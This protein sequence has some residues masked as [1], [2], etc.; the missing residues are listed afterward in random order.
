VDVI[1]PRNA[2]LSFSLL[3]AM[4][5]IIASGAGLIMPGVLYAKATPNWYAQSFGQDIVDFFI[6]VPML[7]ITS[8]L[9]YMKSRK[10]LLLW[11]GVMIY[12]I[13]TF[14]IYCFAVHFN[15]LFVLYCLIL[16]L[17]FYLFVWFILSQYRLKIT[18]WF[19][20]TLPY[21]TISIYILVIGSIFYLLWLMQIIPANINNTVPKELQSAGLFTNPV[22]VLDL[23]VCLPGIIITGILLYRNHPAG[24]L[25]APVVLMFFILMDIT[26]GGLMLVMKWKGLEANMLLTVNMFV[27]AFISAVLLIIYFRSMKK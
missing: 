18:S 6:A 14:A 4:L 25:L 13:Y 10:A 21:Q 24:L 26:I 19:D 1:Y 22:Q 11:A 12:L 23:S 27:L 16:G 17:S 20:P 3:L 5:V 8:V 9:A 2:F 7:I 15:Q